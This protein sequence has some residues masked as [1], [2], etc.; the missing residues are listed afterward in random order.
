MSGVP[1]Y[2]EWQHLALD[3][4]V[5]ED[6]LTV[7]M[8]PHCRECREE[9]SVILQWINNQRHSAVSVSYT[10][11]LRKLTSDY[12][13]EEAGSEAT[14]VSP[15]STPEKLDAASVDAA[16]GAVAAAAAATG[17]VV[18][19]GTTTGPC[20][21][22]DTEEGSKSHSSSDSSIGSNFSHE[23]FLSVNDVDWGATAAAAAPSGATLGP[24]PVTP[25]RVRSTSS[26]QMLLLPGKHRSRQHMH[27]RHPMQSPLQLP[28]PQPRLR[29]CSAPIMPLPL[30][31]AGTGTGTGSETDGNTDG[32]RAGL[33]EPENLASEFEQ[34]AAGQ[35]TEPKH[36]C[37]AN[38]G[39]SPYTPVW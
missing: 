12:I 19:R 15:G 13:G 8:D 16:V 26:T 6:I 28:V 27:Y 1:L 2:A 3:T 35:D 24:A 18:E 23:S 30:P 11:A 14:F 20:L 9:R 37:S 22:I 38:D 4:T 32:P 29:S 7:S 36:S 31:L 33:G 34:A 25:E 5:L 10:Q 17:V 39:I 21:H